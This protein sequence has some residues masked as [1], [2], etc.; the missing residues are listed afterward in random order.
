[1]RLG[2]SLSLTQQVSGFS[3]ASLFSGGQQGAWYDPSDVNTLFQDSAGTTPVTAVGQ[4][5][6]L[7]LDKSGR[8]NHASQSTPGSRPLYQVDGTGRAY[9]S[10]DGVDDWM[11]TPTIT[12]GTDKMQVFAGVR[13]LSD[14]LT[15][16]VAEFS[17]NATTNNG[18]FA[19]VAPTGGLTTYQYWSRG[20]FTR[21]V[22]GNTYPSPDTA[23]LTGLGDIAGD[24]SI[25]RVDGYQWPTNVTDQG[26]GNYLAYPLYI[27]A[28]GGTG[29][30]FNGQLYGLVVRFGANLAASAIVT[31][32]NWM[33]TKTGAY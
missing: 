24:S 30:R 5:V 12:P 1:M 23:V 20:T 13:K 21:S 18:T 22:T 25:L 31:M 33:N 16:I 3:P 6:G 2:I 14:A 19:L 26:T 15:G 4:P 8:G 11:I 10:L 9:L 7:I 27:G 17:A 29:S 28:R 32:E